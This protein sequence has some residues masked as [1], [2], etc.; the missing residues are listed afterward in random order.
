MGAPVCAPAG[1]SY[2]PVIARRQMADQAR[3]DGAALAANP[4]P[5]G[6]GGGGALSASESQIE[7]SLEELLK[8]HSYVNDVIQYCQQSYANNPQVFDETKRLIQSA[9]DVSSDPPK[10]L[11]FLNR[12]AVPA[13]FE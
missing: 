10:I 2:P 12:I 7:L 3:A 8:N 9:I 11:L 13:E 1:S 5:G 6:A 4:E